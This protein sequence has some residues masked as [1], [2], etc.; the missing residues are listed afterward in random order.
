LADTT[1]ALTVSR[2]KLTPKEV[3]L[4]VRHCVVA[5]TGLAHAE[6]VKRGLVLVSRIR[7]YP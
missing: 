7:P 2:F 3:V 4:S 5:R 1:I 6:L